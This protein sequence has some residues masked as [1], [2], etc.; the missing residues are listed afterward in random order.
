MGTEMRKK[1][2]VMELTLVCSSSEVLGHQTLPLIPPFKNW[3]SALF[4][5]LVTLPT[6]KC[7]L[8]SVS[9]LLETYII[10][11]LMAAG[12]FHKASVLWITNVACSHTTE[13]FYPNTDDKWKNR[14]H[15]DMM[16]KSEWKRYKVEPCLWGLSALSSNPDSDWTTGFQWQRFYQW[17]YEPQTELREGNWFFRE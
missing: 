16:G 11:C 14:H 7:T 4:T 1:W 12:H 3:A 13:L 8:T 5:K 9:L 2:L 15:A 17:L 6:R 10:S